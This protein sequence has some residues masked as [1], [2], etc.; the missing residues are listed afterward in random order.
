MK[1]DTIRSLAEEIKKRWPQLDVQVERS[2][3][4]TD[5]KIR[6][7]RLRHPGK[8]RKGMRIIVR[9]KGKIVLDH[10]NAETYRRTADVRDWMDVYAPH[11]RTWP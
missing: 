8:G 3:V 5:R 6:G 4:S 1:R 9:S 7:T 2:E 11:A 10:D